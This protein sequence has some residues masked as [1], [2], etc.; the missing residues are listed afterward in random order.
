MKAGI[1]NLAKPVLRGLW[2]LLAFHALHAQEAVPM[3]HP[4]WTRD[5]IQTIGGVTYLTLGGTLRDCTWLSVGPVT[6][7]GTN[8]SVTATGLVCA[9][10]FECYHTETNVTVLGAL[11]PGDYRLYV[12]TDYGGVDSWPGPGAYLFLIASFSVPKDAGRTLTASVG[13]NAS[14]RIISVAG[15]PNATYVLESSSTL[16]NWATIR[17]NIGGPFTHRIATEMDPQKF[18]RVR[19]LSGSTTSR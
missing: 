12:Y 16:T 9:L 14:E 18:L 13:T 15:V 6:R 10:C 2:V 4:P 8:L 3:G 17:T 5:A 11:P 1:S 7:S 19:I